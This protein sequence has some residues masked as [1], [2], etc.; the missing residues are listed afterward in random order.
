MY[1]RGLKKYLGVDGKSD[2][3]DVDGFFGD[4]CVTNDND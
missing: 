1:W 2:D 3:S 4:I